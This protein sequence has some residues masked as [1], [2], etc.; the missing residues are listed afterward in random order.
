M[1]VRLNRLLPRNGLFWRYYGFNSS[2]LSP[3]RRSEVVFQALEL[4]VWEAHPDE[5]LKIT[6]RQAK[7]TIEQL[8]VEVVDA[9]T[10][11]ADTFAVPPNSWES[12]HLAAQG[13]SD[14]I[15]R[16]VSD[17]NAEEQRSFIERAHPTTRLG[18][19]LSLNVFAAL[20]VAIVDAREIFLADERL[21]H[22]D[23]SRHSPLAQAVD[24]FKAAAWWWY[25]AKVPTDEQVVEEGEDS[26]DEIEDEE[27]EDGIE[28]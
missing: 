10:R 2:I 23:P 19:E 18:K 13:I 16:E 11:F 27:D 26:D 9:A 20:F 25:K 12:R 28:E 21:A 1:V 6:S 8:L 17:A 15:T 22:Q 4:L 14:P 3:E 7:D 5:D 24:R